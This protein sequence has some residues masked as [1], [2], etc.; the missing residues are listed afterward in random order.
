[1]GEPRAQINVRL[2]P[3]LIEQLDRKRI[4]LQPKL[5]K[6]PTRSDVMRLA[7]EAYLGIPEKKI[8]GSGK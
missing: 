6:I 7:L 5:G 1:M 3:E 2:S 8:R 4:E